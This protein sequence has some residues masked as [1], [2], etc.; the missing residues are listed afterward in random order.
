VTLPTGFAVP[1]C[2]NSL[3]ANVGCFPDPLHVSRP[4]QANKIVGK[5]KGERDLETQAISKHVAI[6]TSVGNSAH[7]H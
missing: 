7:A 4:C 2:Q 1:C 5:R 6:Y 3:T